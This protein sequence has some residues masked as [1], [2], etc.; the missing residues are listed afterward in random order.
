MK[1]S[2]PPLAGRGRGHPEGKLIIQCFLLIIILHA[3]RR[4]D[5]IVMER[6]GQNRHDDTRFSII[7]ADNI[8]ADDIVSDNIF[9]DDIVADDI[10]ADDIVADDIVADDIVADDIVADDIVA[11]DVI[12][13]R[14]HWVSRLADCCCCCSSRS[15]VFSGG[16]EPITQSVECLCCMYLCLCLCLCLYLLLEPVI[17]LLRGSRANQPIGRVFMFVLYVFVFVFVFVAQAGHTSSPGEQ[18]QS[19]NRQ[20]VC[21]CVV[22]ICLCCMYLYL[23]LYLLLEPVIRL[24]L[25]SRT[26]HPICRVFLFV[27]YVFVFVFVFVA[28]AGHTSSPGEQSQSPNLQSAPHLR[29][30]HRQIACHTLHIGKHACADG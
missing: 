6:D 2:G 11:D 9:P 3:L 5:N 18:S 19:A 21:V 29:S 23:Y 12:M 8:T 28:R 24:L 17:R 10:V 22:C 14:G 15:Y 27:L 1:V 7:F 25:G 13:E 30:N 4:A 20:N 16:A 26:N